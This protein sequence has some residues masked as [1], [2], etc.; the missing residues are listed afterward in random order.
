M[1][2]QKDSE[3]LREQF[4]HAKRGSRSHVAAIEAKAEAYLGAY[5]NIANSLLQAKQLGFTDFLHSQFTDWNN[6]VDLA[7]EEIAALH[8]LKFE[9]ESYLKSMP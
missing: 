5:S 6:T 8:D 2:N 3:L 7:Q 4:E 1:A 9:I